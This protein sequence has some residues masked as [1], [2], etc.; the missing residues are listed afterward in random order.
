MITRMLLKMCHKRYL[1]TMIDTGTKQFLTMWTMG[2]N[3]YAN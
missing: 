3:N 1:G 2:L